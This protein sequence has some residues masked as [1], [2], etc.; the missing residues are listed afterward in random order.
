VLLIIRIGFCIPQDTSFFNTFPLW[1]ELLAQ[2][3][4]GLNRDRL[5]ILDETIYGHF[6]EIDGALSRCS[7]MLH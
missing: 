1:I 4:N 7:I 3:A 5:S 6:H 2:L